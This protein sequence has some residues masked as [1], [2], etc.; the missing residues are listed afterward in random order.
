MKFIVNEMATCA[1]LL[2]VDDVDEAGDRTGC[3]RWP[4]LR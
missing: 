3:E 1:Y 4:R 2:T